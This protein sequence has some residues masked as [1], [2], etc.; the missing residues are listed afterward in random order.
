MRVCVFQTAIIEG[1]ARRITSGDVPT[2]LQCRIISLDLGALIAGASH[3]GEFE[4]RLKGVLKEVQDSNGSIILFID[5][6]HMLLGAGASGGSMDA[7]NLLKPMLA[8]GQARII[9]ATTLDEY[10]KYVENDSAFERR[11]QQVMVNEPTVIDTISILRGLKERYESH[12][13]VRIADAALVAAAQLSGR[14]ITGRFLP[15]KA[16]DLIDEAAASV[17]VQL[18]S[19][20]EVI[21]R[22][23][24]RELQLDVECTALAAEKDEASQQRLQQ[25]K[26]EL[27]KVREEMRPLK[28]QH[29]AEKQRVENLRNMKQK[30][31][32]LQAKLAQ[33]ERDRNLSLAADLKY[34]AIPDLERSILKATSDM[35]IENERNSE[36]RLLTEE[37]GVDTVAEI[38]S[39]WTGIPV[40]KLG[41]TERE[42]LLKLA[43]HLHHKL[44][45]QDKAVDSVAEAVLRSRAGLASSNRPTGTFMFLGPTGT[46]KTL[47]SKALAEE[48]F[49]DSKN[50]L[51]IDC[52]EYLEAHSVSRLI[53]APPGYIGHDA[54]GQLTEKVRRRPY[55][56]ILLDE[57]RNRQRQGN[58]LR[59]RLF[60]YAIN[61]GY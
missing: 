28:L 29:E 24:R 3:R 37:V 15:D 2:N 35:K 41:Q 49:D 50:M 58:Y 40:T 51:R 48:L 53:G 39:R 19:Q 12:F 13:G 42:R 61:F 31:S 20:P 52:S 47:L 45:G 8:R 23:E 10:R 55:Q 34:G 9:G 32:S 22:L 38:V 21:D 14:Y 46:G 11:F 7:A 16:I 33:A 17:R 44:V 43:D 54:G 6:F 30:L 26:E 1:L 5:E 59:F 56:V 25:V 4:E 36:N 27:A 60:K 57:V 18:D